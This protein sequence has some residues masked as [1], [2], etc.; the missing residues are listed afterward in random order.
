M[1]VYIAVVIFAVFVGWNIHHQDI[2]KLDE[3]KTKNRV[4]KKE[5][6]ALKNK[7]LKIFHGDEIANL[8]GHDVK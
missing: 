8:G 1:F 4:L 3:Q 2:Q 7:K 5:V 6:A